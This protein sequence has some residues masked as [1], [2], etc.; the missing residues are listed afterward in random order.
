[1]PTAPVTHPLGP[2]TISGTDYTVDLMLQQPTRIT[3]MIM[4]LSLQRFIID[5]LFR[6]TGSPSGGAVVFD[7]ADVNELY[8]DRDVEEIAPDGEYPLV[9]SSRRAPQVAR[10]KKYGGRT[11][12]TDE[13]RDRNDVALFTNQVRQITNTIIRKV[14]A[15]TVDVLEAAV[16]TYG[17]TFV[18]QDW[19]TV[20]LEGTSPTPNSDR[21]TA[22][23]M[24]VNNQAFVEELGIVYDT[25][26]VNPQ[27]YL[28]FHII[29]GEKAP[30]VLAAAGVKEM[31]P[32]NRVTP[33]TAYAC[34]S[35]QVGEVK[36]EAP[37]STETWRTPNRDRTDLKAGVRPLMFVNNPM[38]VLKVTG[39]AG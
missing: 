5:R 16:T 34:A 32:S 11:F 9:T 14:N 33:G 2:P 4:D 7:V 39:L 21:P 23:F 10:V 20:S 8:T 22:D 17:R 31:Y 26:I 37:L 38:A 29:Y 28:Q 15:K 6:S 13:A 3:R 27:E 18:G 12:I 24:G 35:G 1:M 25:W 19:S 30:A 36:I